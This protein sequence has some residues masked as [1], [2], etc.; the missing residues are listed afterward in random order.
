MAHALEM[1]LDEAGDSAVRRLWA[2]IDE[3]GVPS[4]AHQTHGKHRPHVTLAIAESLSSVSRARLR[5]VLAKEPIRLDLHTL[6][7]F[8]GDEGAVFLA[9]T[10]NRQ[11][12]SR[13]EG[14]HEVLAENAVEQWGYYLPGSWVPHCTLTQ[15]MTHHQVLVAMGAVL[16]YEPI[17]A[18]V[19]SVGITDTVTGDVE[20]IVL[21]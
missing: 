21:L 4:L 9:V 5:S 2:R 6:G 14:L 1:F 8:P 19:S 17:T 15:R 13:H 16:D 12:I 18:V 11:L 10:T 20:D 3:A 7:T